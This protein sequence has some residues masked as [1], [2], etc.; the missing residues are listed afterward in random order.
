LVEFKWKGITDPRV[1]MSP[2]SFRYLDAFHVFQVTPGTIHLGI[3]HTIVDYS[4]Y[5]KLYTLQGPGEFQL[6][7]VVFSQNFSPARAT[8]KLE[9]GNRLEDIKF[10][11]ET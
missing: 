5:F 8:Y 10:Y 2:K 3:N 9:V 4:G 7:Y 6:T 11:S 1:S